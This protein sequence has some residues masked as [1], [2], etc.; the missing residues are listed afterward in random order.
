MPEQ[1]PSLLPAALQRLTEGLLWMSEIDE[2]FETF[3]WDKELVMEL[4][5][6]RLLQLTGHPA[7]TPVE[8]VDVD[9]FFAAATEEQ[10]WFGDKERE[11]AARYRELLVML[12]QMLRDL[13]VYRVGEVEVAI[14]IV[15]QIETGDWVGLATKALET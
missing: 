9:D 15:G 3:C 13:R 7:D 11:T 4:T 6:A 14:Y 10:E 5:H 12:R 2:P 1:L 8:R